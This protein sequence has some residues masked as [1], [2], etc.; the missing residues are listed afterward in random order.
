MRYLDI[1]KD[2]RVRD[3]R[4]GAAR[5][6]VPGER[7]EYTNTDQIGCTPNIIVST[8]PYTTLPYLL[9]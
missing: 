2:F 7:Y 8:V 1:A 4:R 3:L 9:D 6:F 5:T